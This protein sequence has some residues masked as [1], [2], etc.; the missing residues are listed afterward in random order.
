M[1]SRKRKIKYPLKMKDNYLVRTVEEFREHFDL[2]KMLEYAFTTV[3]GGTGS[4]GTLKNAKL[5]DWL[6]L[7]YYEDEADA[8]SE[9]RE[10]DPQLAE[11][12]CSV[13]GAENP[14][15]QP[16]IADVQ[17]SV[18]RRAYL[19]KLTTANTQAVAMNQEE[20]EQ[21]Y[22]QSQEPIIYLLSVDNKPFV[23]RQ[24]WLRN[25]RIP[26]PVLQGIIAQNQ[27]I[28]QPNIMPEGIID[29][30]I[31]KNYVDL[32]GIGFLKSEELMKAEV[33]KIE[34]INRILENGL[35]LGEFNGVKTKGPVIWHKLEEDEDG[36]LLGTMLK[37][38]T[39]DLSLL[40]LDYIAYQI[41]KPCV[42]QSEKPFDPFQMEMPYS[43]PDS[44]L[45]SFFP[46]HDYCITFLSKDEMEKYKS[47][48]GDEGFRKKSY[49]GFTAISESGMYR[50]DNNYK[51]FYFDGGGSPNDYK[52]YPVIYLKKET[53]LRYYSHEDV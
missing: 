47:L 19:R 37:I 25:P 33:I 8:I 45:C 21:L 18:Q 39:C 46:I 3:E 35:K 42:T 14:K 38:D 51:R 43:I 24:A 1:E 31:L 34:K 11:K 20:F 9:L 7:R 52:C 36:F 10:D 44:D 29:S 53:L 48:F 4:D 22:Q 15:D 12:L 40:G 2:I 32:N 30:F 13:L 28:N 5:T 50:A 49:Y 6:R 16:N 23:F 27:G 17:K 41:I 26:K